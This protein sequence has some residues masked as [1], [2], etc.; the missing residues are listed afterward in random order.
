MS[1]SNVYRI[2]FALLCKKETGNL[3]SHYMIW[4]VRS[5]IPL[6]TLSALAHGTT[7]ASL[8]SSIHIIIC[9]RTLNWKKSKDIICYFDYFDLNYVVYE[10]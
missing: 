6:G 7:F 5:T 9:F 4:L 2:D 10:M 3:L 8:P 1:I